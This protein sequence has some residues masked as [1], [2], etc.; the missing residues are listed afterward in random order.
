M[1]CGIRVISLISPYRKQRE[2]DGVQNREMRKPKHLVLEKS[3]SSNKPFN[4]KPLFGAV[5]CNTAITCAKK[6]NNSF[7]SFKFTLLM[8]KD[9]GGLSFQAEMPIIR[10]HLSYKM[11]DIT[12][13][14]VATV[15]FSGIGIL[16]EYNN[17]T[18]KINCWHIIC[19][20]EKTEKGTG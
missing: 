15:L 20:E 2:G 13:L 9:V 3:N 11:M 10:R 12:E 1:A 6:S 18:F 7:C 5:I 14:M 8:G 17:F 16:A 4:H 19:E